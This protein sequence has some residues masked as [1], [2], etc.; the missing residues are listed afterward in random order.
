[1]RV[2]SAASPRSANPGSEQR[3]DRR[4]PAAR[5]GAVRRRGCAGPAGGRAGRPRPARACASGAREALA[6]SRTAS[7]SASRSSLLGPSEVGVGRQPQH[8]PAARRG[9]PLGVGDAQVVA[10]RLGVGGERA[11]DRRGVG[12]DIGER[13]DGGPAARGP[14]AAAN[15]THGRD[16]SD[17]EPTPPGICAARRRG[18]A[19]RTALRLAS[20]PVS[21]RRRDR[22]GRGLRGPLAPPGAAPVA[23]PGRAVRRARA[24]A[25]SRLERAVGRLSCARSSSRSRTC[26]RPRR[27]PGARPALLP[28][29]CRSAAPYARGERPARADRRLPAAG[30][31]PGP[32]ARAPAR[33]SC[34]T[35]VVERWPSCSA[36]S[37]R[38]STRTT[39]RD[40]DGGG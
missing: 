4:R 39:R 35:V 27:A 33:A 6:A 19:P 20:P 32:R 22:R 3:T 29:R 25:V 37:R 1:M 2:A 10:V 36:W 26:P 31:G 23:H 17:R 15:R 8:L 12:V 30:R 9:E 28:P 40:P 16:G 18:L 21:H 24:H 13:R 5:S 11:E 34:T 14:R 7:A 38:R